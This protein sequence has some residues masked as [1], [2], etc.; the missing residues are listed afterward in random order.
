MDHLQASR[1]VERRADSAEVLLT[2]PVGQL[3]ARAV[4]DDMDPRRGSA[5]ANRRRLRRREHRLLKHVRV[6][7]QV[8]CR[9]PLRTAAKNVEHLASRLLREPRRHPHY[10]RR[11]ARVPELRVPKLLTPT[12]VSLAGLRFA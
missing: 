11:A 10:P 7:E 3:Q 1:S 6:P 12:P 9:L 2:L 5:P 8:V 4:D